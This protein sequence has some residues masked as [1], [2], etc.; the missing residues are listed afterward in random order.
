MLQPGGELDLPEELAGAEH[1]GQLR[2]E[3]PPEAVAVDTIR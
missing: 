3:H 2:M 1:G